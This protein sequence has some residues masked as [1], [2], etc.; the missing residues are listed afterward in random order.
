M[1]HDIGQVC[2]THP[3]ENPGNKALLIPKPAT[4]ASTIVPA[5]DGVSVCL[6]PRGLKLWQITSDVFQC[7]PRV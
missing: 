1:A 7:I 6:G 4:L 5:T 2:S 3:S